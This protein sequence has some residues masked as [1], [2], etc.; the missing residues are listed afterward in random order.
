MVRIQ[1]EKG[2]P[3]KHLLVIYFI[4]PA[5]SFKHVLYLP[6]HKLERQPFIQHI[7]PFEGHLISKLEHF[8]ASLAASVVIVLSM[9]CERDRSL[10]SK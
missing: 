6:W 5:I 10:I 9:E 4:W 3:W 8:P 2:P 1:K 7:G